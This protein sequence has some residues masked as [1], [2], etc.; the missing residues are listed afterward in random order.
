MSGDDRPR[1]EAREAADDL[2]R[3]AYALLFFVACV[4]V[5][6]ALFAIGAYH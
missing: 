1:E 5:V 4:L 6:G 3:L 2:R